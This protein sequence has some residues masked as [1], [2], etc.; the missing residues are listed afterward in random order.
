M[1]FLAAAARRKVFAALQFCLQAPILR[2]LAA[3]PHALL[4]RVEVAFPDGLI[5]AGPQ[6]SRHAQEQEIVY[7][8]RKC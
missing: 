2:R 3:G 7:C 6:S 4:D 8:V 1:R 5:L